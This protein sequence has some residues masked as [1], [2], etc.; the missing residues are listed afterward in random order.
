[1]NT[2]MDNIDD[3]LRQK[4]ETREQARELRNKKL[5]WKQQVARIILILFVGYIAIIGFLLWNETSL[6]YPGSKYPKG[7][8]EPRDFAFEEIEFYSED[9]TKLY[10]WYLPQ[11]TRD[12]TT[13]GIPNA[14]DTSAAETSE[15]KTLESEISHPKSHLTFLL[16]HGNA[17]NIAESGRYMGGQFRQKFNA[18]VFAFDYRGYGKSEGIPFEAG[19]LEDSEAAL[20]WLCKKTNKEPTEIILIGHSLGGGPAVHLASKFGCKVLILQRTF[21]SIAEAGQA[22]YPWLPVKYLMR[23]QYPSFE[24]I[25]TVTAPIFQ[26]HGDADTVIPIRLGKILFGN[27]PAKKKQ[28]FEVEGMTHWDPLPLNYWTELASFLE[29]IDD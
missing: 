13:N 23:N 8:W 9:D 28:F 25:K 12:N 4:R 14:S 1:M 16:C 10:G 29:T 7:D 3:I 2:A 17:E 19:V 20:E 24:K 22:K 11:P 18:D 15:S 21:N 6:V 5:T 26:S 27:S